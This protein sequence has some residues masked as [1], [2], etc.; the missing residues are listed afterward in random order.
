MKLPRDIRTR[1]RLRPGEWSPDGLGWPD[2]STEV[3]VVGATADRTRRGW[4][5]IA[6]HGIECDWESSDCT[7]ACVTVLAART[8]LHR[9]LAEAVGR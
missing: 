4:V 2:E 1:I 8:T 5:W 6:G 9:A 3:I 7:R